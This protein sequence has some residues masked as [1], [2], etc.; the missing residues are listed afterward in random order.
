MHGEKQRLNV[1]NLEKWD[2]TEVTVDL[3]MSTAQTVGNNLI[4]TKHSESKITESNGK[5]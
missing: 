3:K 2:T 5:R 4:T 1:S